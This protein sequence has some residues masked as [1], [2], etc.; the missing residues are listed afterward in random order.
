MFEYKWSPGESDLYLTA[1]LSEPAK[2]MLLERVSPFPAG[3]QRWRTRLDYVMVFTLL[4]SD[5]FLDGDHEEVRVEPE[6]V[7]FIP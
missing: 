6:M 1:C 2:I 7:D 3:P 5:P 4:S